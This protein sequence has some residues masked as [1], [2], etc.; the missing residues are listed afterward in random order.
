[1][2]CNFLKPASLPMG[3]DQMVCWFHSNDSITV[4]VF[5]WV[6]SDATKAAAAMCLDWLYWED[7]RRD[8]SV[9]QD[10]LFFNK[11]D[12]T[13]TPLSVK[14]GKTRYGPPFRAIREQRKRNPSR[15][16]TR[17]ISSKIIQPGSKK[18][19]QQS[20]LRN[21]YV[22]HAAADPYQHICECRTQLH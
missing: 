21:H 16:R 9:E 20:G 10:H 8:G 18:L 17:S 13:K 14:E 7:D 4:T 11:V 3:V 19:T 1:M 6:F 12:S 15:T 2:V 22:L 5:L